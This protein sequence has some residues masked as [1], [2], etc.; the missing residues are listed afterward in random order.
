MAWSFTTDLLA[1]IKQ[2]FFPCF[3]SH[4]LVMTTQ[5]TASGLHLLTSTPKLTFES[6]STSLVNS[7]GGIIDQRAWGLCVRRKVSGRALGWRGEQNTSSWL[8]F[9]LPDKDSICHRAICSLRVRISMISDHSASLRSP[10]SHL[11]SLSERWQYRSSLCRHRRL[12]AHP[13]LIQPSS[14]P[15]PAKWHLCSPWTKGILLALILFETFQMR[16]PAGPRGFHIFLIHTWIMIR[17][18]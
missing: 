1:M 8:L 15:H 16:I 2:R 14:S 12:P 17:G 13:A 4:H 18:K 5:T 9:L 6:F 3:S 11:H 7:G 10:W